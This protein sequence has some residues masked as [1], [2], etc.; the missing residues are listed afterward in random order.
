M[1]LIVD[2]DP[3]L[4]E[5]VAYKLERSG[6][7]VRRASNGDEAMSAVEEERPDVVIL[8]VMMPGLSGLDVLERWRGAAATAGLP[9]ILLTAKTREADV[10]RGFALGASDYI[11]KPF[12]PRELVSRVDAVLARSVH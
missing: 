9:V 10:E 11:T 2:D 3:D 6:F 7:A 5:L 12:S 4:C 1:A 8:D